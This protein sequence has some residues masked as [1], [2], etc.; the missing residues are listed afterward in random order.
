MTIPPP[1]ELHAVTTDAVVATANAAA[2]SRRARTTR[3]LSADH[4]A[5][6]AAPGQSPAPEP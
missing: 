2:H 5:A 6:G 4:V 1:P 3:L